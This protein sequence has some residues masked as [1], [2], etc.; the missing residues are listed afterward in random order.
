MLLGTTVMSSWAYSTEVT[1]GPH[2]RG[3]TLKWTCGREGCE[4]GPQGAGQKGREGP[5]GGLCRCPPHL[6]L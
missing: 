4:E 1:R 2:T 6:Q 5:P 3:A